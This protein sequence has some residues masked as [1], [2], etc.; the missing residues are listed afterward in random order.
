MTEC[1]YFLVSKNIT[2]QDDLRLIDIFFLVWQFTCLNITSK[3]NIHRR[4]AALLAL[5]LDC[6][7]QLLIVRRR[8]FRNTE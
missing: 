6:Q 5:Q 1:V 2:A 7:Y 3:I 8:L 4:S